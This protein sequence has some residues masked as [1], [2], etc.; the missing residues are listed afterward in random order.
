MTEKLQ[1]TIKEEILKLPKENQEVI[2]SLDWAK[3]AEEIGKKYLLNENE[4]NDL[5]VETLLILVGV[6]DFN[7]F[8]TN[9]E[10]EIVT[11]KDTAEKIAGEITEK[12]FT[13]INNNFIEKIKQSGKIKNGDAEQ[14]LN[15]ILSNGDYSAFMQEKE[16]NT[17]KLNKILMPE[18]SGIPTRPRKMDDLRSKFT[19]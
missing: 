2:N 16:E 6:Q 14:N 5:Q 19:I 9:I 17:V 4:V 7:Y 10:N 3:I 12:I 1:Q 13:P 8:A 18:K 15:F 11:S